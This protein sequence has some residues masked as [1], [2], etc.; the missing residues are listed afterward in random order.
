MSSMYFDYMS[1]TPVHPDV[2]KC[3]LDYLSSPIYFAN[4]DSPH[5]LGSSCRV[6]FDE[7]STQ[8]LSLLGASDAQV[9][10]TS[11]A[12][13]SINLALK[14]A[15]KQYHR[16]GKHIITWK[17]EHSATLDTLNSLEKE[18]F[19]VTMLPVLPDGMIDI[20]LL[21]RSI[22]ADTIL[23][24]FTHVHNELGCVQDIEAIARLCH[25]RGVL[26]HVDCAQTLGKAPVNLSPFVTYASFSAH[27]C[28]GPKGVGALL[29]LDANRPL[30]KQMHGGHQQNNKRAGTIPL[31]LI[32]G[33]VRSIE[34][35]LAHYSAQMAK[36]EHFSSYCKEKLHHSILWN[37]TVSQ[38]TPV[39]VNLLMPSSVDLAR[40]AELK[41]R[42][43][44]SS[45]AACNPYAM[46]HV[47]TAIGR[48]S[49]E[50]KRCLRISF[51]L[52]TTEDCVVTL[53]DA[54]NDCI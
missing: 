28:N 45:H 1:S 27:K 17:T 47:L 10:W 5:G 41:Q 34:L 48:S 42:Y 2:S 32:A 21:E 9:V 29:M 30:Q 3:M 19:S 12:T 35:T 49:D 11:G 54:I 26:T 36:Y 31:F 16:A 15:A 23:V 8:F 51:G 4:P 44:L 43:A 33:F 6:R 20:A 38:R 53:V 14:G 25:A 46:S 7:L 39:N 22:R 18:G 40:L 37:G 24:T 13:E 50:Q 52:Q